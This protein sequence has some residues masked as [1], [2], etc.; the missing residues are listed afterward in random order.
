MSKLLLSFAIAW[1]VM[2]GGCAS[3][4]MHHS[5]LQDGQAPALSPKLLAVYMPWFGD[6]THMDV[7]YTSDDSTVLHQQIQK[8]RGMGISAFV[9]DWYGESKPYS[10]HNFGL[11]QQAASEAHFKVAL[12]YNE[13]EDQDVQ[14]TDAAIAAFDKAY[15]AYIGPSAKYHDA[16]LTYDGR[17]M[18]FIFPKSGHVDWNRVQESFSGWA[19]APLLIYKDQP[20]ADYAKDFAGSYAWVQPGPGGWAADGSN[21]GEEYLKYFYKTMKD[22]HPDKI[23]IGGAWPA[24]MTLPQSGVSIGTCKAHAG[25][26]LM[27]R[28]PFISVTTTVPLRPRSCCWKPGTTTRRARPSNGAPPWIVEKMQTPREPARLADSYLSSIPFIRQPM[29]RFSH[30]KWAGYRCKFGEICKLGAVF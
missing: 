24:S 9:V 17:P 23:A 20:T 6:H 22:S 14:A 11:L 18:L 21:W 28:S 16:Y 29:S 7:G 4:A 5:V 26:P 15:K 27:Q 19:A 25:R 1:V 10:D 12:L 3:P 8:A 2:F 13:S 30:Q